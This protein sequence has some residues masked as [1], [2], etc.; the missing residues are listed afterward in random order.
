MAYTRTVP[1]LGQ[2][3]VTRQVGTVLQERG[4]R[5]V[6]WMALVGVV[7]V[8]FYRYGERWA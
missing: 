6:L 7:A 1:R 5:I 8:A 4:G 2:V 3:P